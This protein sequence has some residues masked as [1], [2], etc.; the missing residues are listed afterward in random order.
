MERKKMIQR[1]AAWTGSFILMLISLY[2]Y[3]KNPQE[4]QFDNLI[5][6]LLICPITSAI[7]SYLFRKNEAYRTIRSIIIPS[8]YIIMYL[9]ISICES[10]FT[11]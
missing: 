6:M 8:N 11:A 7:V 2:L 1:L 9:I 3:I 5:L 10:L 4:I